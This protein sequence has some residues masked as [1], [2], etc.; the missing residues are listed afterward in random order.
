[1]GTI[2]DT[3]FRIFSHFKNDSF[4]YL[5]SS[6]MRI[7]RQVAQKC[8]CVCPRTCTGSRI[9]SVYLQLFG[10]KKSGSGGVFQHSHVNSGLT[11]H[12]NL[13]NIRLRPAT[14]V[15]Q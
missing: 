14:K 13:Y 12:F 3:K 4:N 9:K 11:L 1:M 15:R 5:V 10:A 2:N 6:K 7:K 8:E